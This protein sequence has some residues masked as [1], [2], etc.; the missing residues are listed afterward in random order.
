MNI[1]KVEQTFTV[2]DSVEFNSFEV[3]HLVDPALKGPIHIDRMTSKGLCFRFK[4]IKGKTIVEYGLLKDV[5]CDETYVRMETF[6][7]LKHLLNKIYSSD[8]TCD[9]I[10]VRID[11]LLSK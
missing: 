5:M 4:T 3:R 7:K 8:M 11:E 6:Y 1:P 2:I 10:N 9:D